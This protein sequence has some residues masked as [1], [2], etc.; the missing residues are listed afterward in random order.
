M[1]SNTFCG[2][3][4]LP[5]IGLRIILT[6]DVDRFPQTMVRSGETGTVVYADETYIS[7]KLDTE[8]YGLWCWDNC[9]EWYADH[10]VHV[11]D[12]QTLATAFWCQAASH[13][14]N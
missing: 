5:K 7:V 13:N 8:H 2:N 14:S 9:V 11:T 12:G 10:H 6:E 3:T 4:E 1:S